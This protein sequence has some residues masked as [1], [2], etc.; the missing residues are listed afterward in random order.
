MTGVRAPPTAGDIEVIR[1]VVER[2]A[3][4]VDDHKT[5]ALA[6]EVQKGLPGGR[7]P[8][9]DLGRRAKGVPVADQGVEPGKHRRVARFR[10]FS[11]LDF[12]PAAGGQD[13][14]QGRGGLMPVVIILTRQDEHANGRLGGE[15]GERTQISPSQENG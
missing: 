11:H 9:L 2:T 7:G 15:N 12:E 14:L 6:H 5:A 8:V 4:R 3:S 13:A 1:P 10:M